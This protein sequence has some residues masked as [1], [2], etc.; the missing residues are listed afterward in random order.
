M[1]LPQHLTYG[2]GGT[3]SIDLPSLPAN[4][5]VSV[6]DGDGT[7]QVTRQDATVSTVNTALRGTPSAG[8]KAINV[9]SGTGVAV[10]MKLWIQ[11]DPEESTVRSVSSNTVNLRRPLVYDHSNNATVQQA[12][13]SYAVNAA[14]AAS[15]FW[16]G[17]A[18]WNIGGSTMYYTAVECTR[19]P[20]T[21]LA[22][23]NDIATLEPMIYQ[24]MDSE[25]DVEDLLDLAFEHVLSRIASVSQ[26]LRVR[27]FT[28]S[29]VFKHVTALAFLQMLYM[30][31]KGE[32][33][34]D[35][36]ERYRAE[37]TA[38]IARLCVTTPRDADQDGVVEG[39]ERI[40]AGTVR[41]SRG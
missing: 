18:E 40:S 1:S 10:G 21:R 31:Q 16:D 33:A 29:S 32:D 30:R 8:D 36:W 27:V 35:L 41:L 39:D 13:V 23:V 26:D 24:L 38:E 34:R 28:A 5:I 25:D 11:D 14:A 3:V 17:R 37:V 9:A 2:V 7:Y 22:T 20:L 15:L 19:Y 12:R 4:G 6:V